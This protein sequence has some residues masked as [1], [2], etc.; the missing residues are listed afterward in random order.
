MAL[1]GRSFICQSSFSLHRYLEL[2]TSSIPVFQMER[3]RH[4]AQPGCRR[5][6]VG[7][8]ALL[9][10]WLLVAFKPVRKGTG[11]RRKI[12]RCYVGKALSWMCVS[13]Q[14]VVLSRGHWKH[15]SGC[16]LA[17]AGFIGSV[18]SVCMVDLGLLVKHLLGRCCNHSARTLAIISAFG[19]LIFKSFFF[20]P[21]YVQSANQCSWDPLSFG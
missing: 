5:Q 1:S 8:A 20:L 13:P 17:L 19:K 10:V 21:N 15:W 7:E 16:H 12:A 6:V 14:L 11:G 2:F 18:L 3:L 9:T 4:R